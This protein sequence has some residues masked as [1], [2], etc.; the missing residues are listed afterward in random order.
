[1]PGCDEVPVRG[2]LCFVDAEFSLFA[3]PFTIDGVVVSWGRALNEQHL[4]V[5]GPFDEDD[6]TALHRHL[7]RSFPPAA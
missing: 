7:A 6:R 2:A 3:K 1:M 4:L 5:P